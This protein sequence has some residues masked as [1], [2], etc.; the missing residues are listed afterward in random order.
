MMF[1]ASRTIE[2]S[3]LGATDRYVLRIMFNRCAVAGYM[4]SCVVADSR[5][6]EMY[7]TDDVAQRTREQSEQCKNGTGYYL[8]R[9]QTTW[10]FPCN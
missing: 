3:G 7:L 4:Y 10:C 9:T 5:E 8:K 1:S 6:G 2:V